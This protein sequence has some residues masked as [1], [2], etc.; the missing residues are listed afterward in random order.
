MNKSLVKDA[1]ILAVIT[2]VAGILLGIV[3]EITKDPIAKAQEAATQ[4][5]RRI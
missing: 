1:L 5:G 4:A 3:Y 2:L